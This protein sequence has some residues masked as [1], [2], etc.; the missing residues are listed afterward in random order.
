MSDTNCPLCSN[1]DIL[2][3]HRDAYRQYLHCPVCDLVFVHRDHYLSREEEL[4]RYDHHQNE[5][6]DPGYRKFLSQMG[7]PMLKRISPTST[8]L[9]FGSGPGPL[10]AQ[11]FVEAGH[12]MA[13]FDTFYAPD[14]TVFSGSYDFITTT[15]VAE[16]LH[17]PL[18]EFDRL[19]ACLK[20]GGY[21][22]V[23]T[24]QRTP[25]LDFPAWHYIKDETHVIFFSPR[26]M[27]W[28]AKRWGAMLE[29]I[30]SSVVIFQKQ[31]E[32]TPGQDYNPGLV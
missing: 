6:H 23:M 4:Q 22:G 19:W 27:T 16:H 31:P 21:L 32:N 18:E 1:P 5:L 3:Y 29:F 9:D 25:D 20:P 17:R 14:E 11:M 8:G 13:L 7:I 2:P 30:S 26:T 24:S 15:E 28:L 10:L 12:D